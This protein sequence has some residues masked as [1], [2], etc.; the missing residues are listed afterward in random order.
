[1]ADI[2]LVFSCSVISRLRRL[3]FIIGL[4]IISFAGC[5]IETPSDCPAVSFRYAEAH[6]ATDWV[7]VQPSLYQ[8]RLTKQKPVNSET[9]FR[10]RT[11][12]GIDFKNYVI[13]RPL[14]LYI[15]TG[16]G[17]AIADYDN[18]GSVRTY[19]NL[20]PTSSKTVLKLEGPAGNSSC[21]G[22]RAD[23]VF[24]DNTR[25]VEYQAGGGYLS[26]SFVPGFGLSAQELDKLKSVVVTWPDGTSSTKEMTDS[27]EEVVIKYVDQK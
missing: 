4:L 10:R 17:V 15:E 11:D 26:Q 27:A 19:E 7:Q 16:S 6:S 3:C 9:K 8:K 12:C 13:K 2:P 24:E 1:M 22:C 23:V 18:D 5:E 21:V 25:V 20:S 14:S